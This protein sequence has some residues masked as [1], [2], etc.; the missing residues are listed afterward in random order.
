MVS[1][2]TNK[3]SKSSCFLFVSVVAGT[4]FGA[5]D[6]FDD[7]DGSGDNT[8]AATADDDDTNNDNDMDPVRW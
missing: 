3:S 7:D 6:G 4:K 2:I 8:A 1:F 5:N